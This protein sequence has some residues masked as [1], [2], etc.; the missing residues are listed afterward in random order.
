MLHGYSLVGYYKVD[1]LALDCLMSDFDLMF[2]F[3]FFHRDSQQEEHAA[4]GWS[5]IIYINHNHVSGIMT[6]T[7]KIEIKLKFL[8]LTTVRK[9]K[10]SVGERRKCVW[11]PS[12]TTGVCSNDCLC[13]KV[14]NGKDNVKP[15]ASKH[16][17]RHETLVGCK[18]ETL[19]WVSRV[20]LLSSYLESGG[21]T[22]PYSTICYK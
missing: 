2:L 20:C 7:V 12:G 11:S 4:E 5:V 22:G 8:T 19:V 15:P 9:V 10:M 21:T 16:L 13:M 1:M 6:T 14:A 3:L 18:I 17:D